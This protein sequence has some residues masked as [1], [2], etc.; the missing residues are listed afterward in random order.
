MDSLA[1]SKEHIKAEIS[2]KHAH[3]LIL[4]VVFTNTCT[5][6]YLKENEM[7]AKLALYT[8]LNTVSS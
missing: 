1:A 8:T 2:N 3:V 7:G 6:T 4:Q 5:K